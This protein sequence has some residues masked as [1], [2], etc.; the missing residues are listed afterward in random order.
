MKDQSQ[1]FNVMNKKVEGSFYLSPQS[2]KYRY[3]KSIASS[4]YLI[5]VHIINNTDIEI[6][7]IILIMNGYTINLFDEDFYIYD[8]SLERNYNESEKA[9]F[10]SNRKIE[11]RSSS[12]DF[13][14]IGFENVEIKYKDVSFFEI[15]VPFKFQNH[16]NNFISID[17]T[18]K[19]FRTKN[20]DYIIPST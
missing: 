16:N 13:I 17:V 18:K 14:V 11:A 8:S 1:F 3:P 2:F 10:L 4:P 12:M 9:F 5:T 19:F 15:T 6:D 7:N 20:S